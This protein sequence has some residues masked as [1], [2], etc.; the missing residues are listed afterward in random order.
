[1]T[2]EDVVLVR[3]AFTQIG[4]EEGW[5]LYQR[6][7]EIVELYRRP[8]AMSH[9]KWTYYPS[10]SVQARAHGQGDADLDQVIAAPAARG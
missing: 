6:G 8:G 2:D 5:A 10:Q 7:D 9:W 4:D 1:M 3:N